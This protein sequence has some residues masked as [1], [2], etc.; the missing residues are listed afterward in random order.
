MEIENIDDYTL[1]KVLYSY[2]IEEKSHRWIQKEILGL[3]A[4]PRGG[5][6]VAMNILHH[7][8]IKGDS[9]GILKNNLNDIKN[10]TID[11]QTILNSFI[12]IQEEAKKIIERK[13]INSKHKETE[14]LSQVKTRIYQDVLKKYL[15]ENYENCCALCEIDQPELL[16][17][18][19]IIPWSVDKE[20]RLDLSNCILLCNFH[21]KLFDKGFISL[22]EKFRV[23][24]SKKLSKNVAKLLKDTVFKKPNEDCPNQEY[25][26]LHR[27][28]IY[29]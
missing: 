21:D 23:I 14:R 28:E 16:V 8:E 12:A 22:D 26:N 3:P 24:I 5:G 11:A 7:F 4:P 20:K 15:S 9:K 2:L 17:A 18:S 6:F 25:L 29:R 19:H 10:I 27:E 1:A 13:P